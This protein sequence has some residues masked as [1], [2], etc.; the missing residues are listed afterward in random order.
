MLT[1]RCACMSCCLRVPLLSARGYATCIV[2]AKRSDANVLRAYPLDPYA[3]WSHGC[4][5]VHATEPCRR[6]H[7]AHTQHG[8]PAI[9]AYLNCHGLLA[10]SI[11]QGL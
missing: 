7:I 8:F 4:A 2:L 6:G 1:S 10:Y 11:F 3:G 5:A 9:W